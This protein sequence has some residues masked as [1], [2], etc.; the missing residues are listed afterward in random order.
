M[1]EKQATA[2]AQSLTDLQT[3]LKSLKSLLIARRPTSGSLSPSLPA[4]SDPAAAA[5]SPPRAS[6]FTPRTPGI[7]SWQLKST[8]T[9]LA[10]GST[11][12]LPAVP[13]PTS[14]GG[15]MYSVPATGPHTVPAPTT[16][17]APSEVED[18]SASGI[19]VEKEDGTP[20]AEVKTQENET[21]G[22]SSTGGASA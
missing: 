18:T 4:Y 5:S 1:L 20:V 13:T 22:E 6:S 8:A 17:A 11:P 7:P 3:E 2:Q 10:G 14:I 16:P 15:G 19:L 9:G 12:P 21:V